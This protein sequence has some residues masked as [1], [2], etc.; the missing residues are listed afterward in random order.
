MCVCVCVCVEG[1]KR[2]EVRNTSLSVRSRLLFKSDD[3]SCPPHLQLFDP[4]QSSVCVCCNKYCGL[5]VHTAGRR[6]EEREEERE[7]GREEERE[8]R[9]GGEG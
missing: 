1:G 5:K 3:S 2:E 7:E 4:V 8:G 9:V 6:E